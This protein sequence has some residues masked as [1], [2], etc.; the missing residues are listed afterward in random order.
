M[1]KEL[2]QKIVEMKFD[3]SDFEQKVAQSLV[4]LKQ[5]KESTKM[6]DAG[7]GLENLSKSAKN[8]DL[9]HIADG[10]E[11]LNARFSNLGIVGM[12]IM[13]RLTNA[14][15]DMGQKIGAAITEA[16][17]DGWKEYEL[18]L[19]SVKTILNSAKTADGLPV[20]LDQVNQKLAELN[21]YSDKT[22]Y[23]FSDMTNNIG[24]FTNAGV[25]LDSAVTAIQ[26][27]ANVAA[28]AG[29]N[30]SDASR[31]MY[32][33]GQALGSGSVKLID[34]KSIENANMATVDFKEQLIQTALELKTV[35]KEGDKY[36]STTKNMQGKVSDVFTATQGFNDSLSAQWMTSE[37][38]T[39][40]LAKYTDETTELGQAAIDA[41]TQ[42]TTFSK[43]IDTLKESMG[44]GWMTTWQYIF[45][46]FEESKKLWTDVYREL[47]G[48]IQKV[49][50]ARNEF[51]KG[52][53]EAGG[54][55]QLLGAL[56]N[57]WTTVKY[58]ATLISNA[59]STAFPKIDA[60]PIVA[61][62]KG[63]NA[64]TEKV[65]PAQE[66]ID[67]LTKTVE[68]TAEAV[69]EVAERAEKFNEIVQQ[70]INGDWGNGQ[71]RI[72]RLH[73]AGYAFENLQNAVNEVLGCEK[74]YETV[75]SDNEAVGLSANEVLSE[76]AELLG[77]QKTNLEAIT[78]QVKKQNPIVGNLAMILLGVSSTVKVI[79]KAASGL[80]GTIAKGASLI[81]VLRKG[82]SFILDIFGTIGAKLYSFNSWILSFS[83]FYGVL[84]GIRMRLSQMSDRLK[85]TGISFKALIDFIELLR[86]GLGKAERKVI[87][88][89]KK[90]KDGAKSV[91]FDG[92]KN[93]LISIGKFIGGALL[94]SLNALADIIVRVYNAA[95]DLKDTLAAMPIIQKITGHIQEM[96]DEL[97]GL[98]GSMKD[99]DF[100][101]TV[102]APIISGISNT[103]SRLGTAILPILSS[104]FEEIK[105][106]LVEIATKVEELYNKLKEDGTLEK[107]TT[108]FEDFKAAL[109]DIPELITAFYNA[110]KLGRLPLLEELPE[111]AKNF[112]TSFTDLKALV[113]TKIDEKFATWLTT[114]SE[115]FKKAPT[116]EEVGPF[117][118]FVNKMRTAFEDFKATAET[119]G[120]AVA[121][122]STKVA[123]VLNK[124]DFRG[125]VITALI[126]SIAIFVFRWSKV[127]KSASKT[128]KALATFI[129][130]GGQV[131]KSASAKYD[132]FLKIAAAIGILA[133]SI[134]LV[135][136]IPADRFR[137][138]CIALGVGFA[139]M[140]GIITALSVMQ[141]PEGKMKEIG[142]AFGGLGVG[143]LAIAVA[144]KILA[145]MDLPQL[146]KGG[147]ALVVFMV[148]MTK[149]VKAA[150][151]I[152]P[153]A[154]AAFAGLGLALLLLA[155]SIK[156]FSTMDAHTLIKGGA[157]VYV[158]MQMIARSAKAAGDAKGAF[159]AFLG[160][161]LALLLLIPSIKLL[162][163]MDAKTLIKGGAAVAALMYMLSDAA[164][165]ANGG[166]KGF[167]GMAIAIGVI[168]GAMYVL[169]G[170]PWAALVTSAHA[171]SVV[172]TS[173]AEAMAKIGGM[174]FK[175][176]GKALAGLV[177][178][179]VV[180]GGALWLLTKF[181]DGKEQLMAA[182]GISAILLAFSLMGPTIETLSKIPFQAGVV[183][184]GNAMVFFGAMVICL[185]ALGEISQMGG[186]KAGDAIVNGCT[187]IGRAISG[188]LD[189][190]VGDTF[191]GVGEMV[192]SI[193]EHLSSFGQ[194]IGGFI[195]GLSNVDEQT[196][197]NAKNL[198]LA[199]LAIC[200][201]DLLDALTGWLRGSHDLDSFSESFEPL[202]NAVIAMNAAL[203][204]ETLDSEKIGQMADVVTKMTEL[205]DAVPKTGGKL[206]V[207]TGVK[208]LSAFATD[209]N[210]FIGEGGFTDFMASVD[211]LNISPTVLAKMFMI[212]SSTS[213]MIDL[214]NALPKSG[215]ISTFI[216]G[217]AD[218]GEFAANMAAFLA[219]DKYGLFVTRVDLV[220]DADLGKLRGNIIPATQEMIN[221]ASKIKANTSIIDAITG[222]T[223]LGK[224][225]ETLAD[226]GGGI[227]K[228]SLSIANVSTFKMGSVIDSVLRIAELN[229]RGTIK[230][231]NL[232]TFGTGITSIGSAL[233]SFSTATEGVALERVTA[234][235]MGL[236]NLHELMMV[237]A[238]SDYSGV[239]NFAEAMRKLAETSVTE[240][241]EGF[242]TNTEEA[243]LAIQ[244]FTNAVTEA[245]TGDPEAV[246]AKARSIITTFSSEIYAPSG[247]LMMQASG[248][249]L[250]NKLID[251]INNIKE[252]TLETSAK[253][254]ITTLSAEIYA[255][256]G[257]LIMKA[258]GEH[259]VTSIV[260]G[261][262]AMLSEITKAAL[263]IVT[264]YGAGILSR[265]AV[266]SQYG[267]IMV[268]A[269]YNG[270][271]TKNEDF[272]DLGQDAA[273]GYA[274]G[275]RSKAEDAARE[276][277]EMVANAI[278]AAQREQDSASPS[279]VFR[280]LGQDGGEGYALGFGDMVSMV[281]TSVRDMGHA[282]IFA[283]QDTISHIK[284]SVDSGIDF[285]P[286]ITPVLDLSQMTSGVT[287]ANAMLSSMQLNGLAATA[288]ITIANQH[289]AALAQAKAVEPID[290]T[291]YLSSLIENTR[292]TTNAVRENRYAIIDGD[293]AFD[294]FDRRLGMA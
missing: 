23:S 66:K 157:A 171:M 44:S 19:D 197:T 277:R 2:E 145:T 269:A 168:T 85:D 288:A 225:G 122:F 20:T 195:D 169:S 56:G 74:R 72:D 146:V 203:A 75:M 164:K 252:G 68:G 16:P 156:I 175:D 235:V 165:R 21:E 42:V 285:N 142:T 161:S 151:N 63:F 206:Q 263:T 148:L 173:V 39:K 13:Q 261:I 121:L 178:A 210:E 239:D 182:L 160:I 138:A 248:E 163:N 237:I 69:T 190:F 223:N 129:K 97:K 196:V 217:T 51:L 80:W 27:V 240:F 125:G 254:I 166:S 189:G 213:A 162:S 124:I 95:K 244:G 292:N 110:L 234:V 104:I 43:M 17:T 48:I 93:A 90:F 273:D 229:E 103:L 88:F 251:G 267:N 256:G 70:I 79:K 266:L 245:L 228:F 50:G 294:Y 94:V 201:A 91:G 59:F 86:T 105:K 250:V 100:Y 29:A 172:L 232:T 9:S 24:K 289:N 159:G 230:T 158:F 4:T 167:F 118:G 130:N 204:N 98:V 147:G 114:I 265:R 5:L 271:R 7:K 211:S 259:M 134:W 126:G 78:E 6:E 67:A 101:A 293:S 106:K 36:V 207:L 31:A 18:N 219:Y 226:F 65:R 281:V 109:R 227:E 89:F 1:N 96:W 282:G 8:L 279:K 52:W 139:A 49:A 81:E 113:Q 205:A 270:A 200:G 287:S 143:L 222:R 243:T 262:T 54:R 46:D 208:D 191:N 102:L 73:E 30:A 216:D 185:G 274:R 202:T 61:I 177:G 132:A 77:E 22:I 186:G 47:D 218:L 82:L 40:T 278:T 238:D 181:G 92:L 155:P 209:M 57:I 220:G 141:I 144:A 28:L 11:Q 174:E 117:A 107:A 286:V 150:G 133:G 179:I 84:N 249:H 255:P 123:D 55:D 276:A 153:G 135:A 194:S 128:L 87:E 214:A 290:Y 280:G 154:G 241:V 111:S 38:L 258:S 187:L 3:N 236:T 215:I 115:W 127:G 257:G 140:A 137:E 284:D 183:A 272:Y 112:V 199:I 58:Y 212:T 64:L 26:G 268:A 221:L 247:G 45:G 83:N 260:E 41:A 283:M 198:A 35:R 60:T 108:A 37:V 192:S 119:A 275:I 291:K 76:N 231:N 116:E 32:N 170:L 180:V 131:A 242:T 99:A 33:F 253:G 62:S 184:A 152:G 233:G 14:A 12:T 149:A 25:D 10:I 71:E 188:F 193:G 120:G 176:I 136:S 246:K 53:K 34:W 264:M 224:F 15:I